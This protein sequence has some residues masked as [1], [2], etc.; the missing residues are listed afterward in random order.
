MFPAD[1]AAPE[2]DAAVR[3]SRV[4]RHEDT[5]AGM[6]AD[7]AAMDAVVEGVLSDGGGA[8][9]RASRRVQDNAQTNLPYP[10][11]SYPPGWRSEERR[12]GKECVSTCR[13]RW[14]PYHDKNKTPTPPSTQE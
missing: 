10:P 4:Q 3:G 8:V 7:A 14:S 9:R 11:R 13:P 1:V 12:G 2:D 6:K 5:P